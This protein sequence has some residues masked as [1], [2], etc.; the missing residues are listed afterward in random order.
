MHFDIIIY[1]FS[2]KPVMPIGIFNHSAIVFHL[3]PAQM[4]FCGEID[5]LKFEKS[6]GNISSSSL[7]LWPS[8]S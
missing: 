3:K 7:I 6:C 5:I 2:P 4:L 1:N 8:F